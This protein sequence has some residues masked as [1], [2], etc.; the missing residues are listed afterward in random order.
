MTQ[1]TNQEQISFHTH[2]YNRSIVQILFVIAIAAITV[3]ISNAY[4]SYTLTLKILETEFEK[5]ETA[6]LANLIRQTDQVVFKHI[7]DLDIFSKSH[8]PKHFLT[9]LKTSNYSQTHPL[10]S[11]IEDL[12]NLS[13]KNT[14]WKRIEVVDMSG[15]VK[16][17]T[18]P[19]FS[20]SS[21]TFE[22][23]DITHEYIQVGN[24][25]VYDIADYPE[26]GKAMLI[27]SNVY[28]WIDT[29]TSNDT[30]IVGFIYGYLAPEK[31]FKQ[32]KLYTKETANTQQELFTI[33]NTKGN[34]LFQSADTT[35]ENA[36][37]NASPY[38]VSLLQD[39]SEDTHFYIEKNSTTNDTEKY[40]THFYSRGYEDYQGFK[41]LAVGETDASFIRENLRSKSFAHIQYYI[42]AVLF[43]AFLV[44]G[45][46][47]YFFTF[48]LSV[49]TKHLE[50]SITTGKATPIKIKSKGEIGK[51]AY[52]FNQFI[53]SIEKRS[54]QLNKTIENT[55]KLNKELEST[56]TA[57]LNVL[58]DLDEE[59]RK[60]D[61]TVKLRTKELVTEQQKLMHITE[62]M[63]VGVIL[64][65]ES[66]KPVFVNQQGKTILGLG[67]DVS[68]ALNRLVEIF[69]SPEVTK[70][71]DSYTLGKSVTIQ[72]IENEDGIFEIMARCDSLQ[73][74][75]DLEFI[76]K[77]IWI[78][79]I[80]KEKQLERS[81][82]ELVAV[83]SHQLRTPL[84]V[85]RGNLEMLLDD[86]FGKINKKQR[87]LLS[88]S[89]ESVIRLIEMVNDMLDITKIEKG[90]AKLI[91]ESFNVME[92]I[93]SVVARLETYANRQKFD[94]VILKP[95]TDIIV[96]G[97]RS[98]LVQVI[99][100]L[101]DNALHYG[102][103]NGKVEVSFKVKKKTV[104]ISISDNGIGIPQKEQGAI[105][106]RFF[107]AS[108]A[109]KHTTGGSG[110]G[111]FIVKA[112]IEQMK[113]SISF[114]SKEGEGTT[115]TLTLPL[116]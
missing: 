16:A 61:E 115:F 109:V 18:A 13:V 51:L 83:A 32:Y 52:V 56:K 15:N 96:Q 99:Q 21:N 85:T 38:I 88:D 36:T 93:D 100:N 69:P 71:I 101:V 67:N 8:I 108:N 78:R 110:L 53:A 50:K 9:E 4:F 33:T 106:Q 29:E 111:L 42:P 43:A 37:Q 66:G 104:T 76:G 34:I 55:Q 27:V 91:I 10:S 35:P 48:P 60:V 58:E 98:R 11:V 89:Q 70:L 73:K 57:T 23:L 94:I 65:D 68:K 97:D 103:E 112:Y 79:N 62:N 102:K 95:E 80:T 46:T 81:K 72:E 6:I 107:R 87:E 1:N 114:I 116:A 77:G 20:T 31:I 14:V 28:I 49:I 84:T 74:N 19:Q 25:K 40:I 44:F 64:T 39:P 92:P 3:L 2:W 12:Q 54:I 30:E 47:A 90:D 82:S 24:T 105:F 22:K 5:N 59:K 17:S 41:W 7:Q 63:F 86:C 26:I 75:T 45:F 113:G